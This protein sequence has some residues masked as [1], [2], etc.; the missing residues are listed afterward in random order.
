MAIKSIAKAQALVRELKE[1]LEIRLAGSAR[2]DT[3][4]EASDAE[5]FPAL[6]L[7]NGGV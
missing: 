3:V 1:R 2:I 5:G 7:S 4:R 6:F